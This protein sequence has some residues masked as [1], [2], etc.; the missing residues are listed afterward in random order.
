MSR[1]DVIVIDGRAYD[2]R[3]LCELGKAQLEAGWVSQGRQLALFDLKTDFRPA[4]E[5][6]A[7]RRYREPDLL[8][9]MA[10]AKERG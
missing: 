6:T 1:H 4:S 5:R 10:G 8:G 9:L 2:W 7:A 3:R